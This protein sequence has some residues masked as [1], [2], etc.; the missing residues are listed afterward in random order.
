MRRIRLPLLTMLLALIAAVSG[1]PPGASPDALP[2][3][4][5]IHY[6][7]LSD[8]V[9]D[10]RGRVVVVDF[11]ADYCA[12]CKREFPKLVDLHQRYSRDGLTVLTLS[13]D[14]P[15]DTDARERVRR[16]L[17]DRNATCVNYL[18]DEPPAVWQAKLKI[19]GPPC[20]F[21][22]NRRGELLKKYHDSVDYADI[23]R[24][25]VDALKQ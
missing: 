12:P 21:V 8:R 1:N 16:F 10:L 22:F 5:T 3:V 24:I 2:T 7:A 20:V 15:A 23:E 19:D 14:D 9:Q 13:L 11:W 4:A 6:D 25:V 17:R 18:L